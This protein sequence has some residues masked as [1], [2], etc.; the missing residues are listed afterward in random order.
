MKSLYDI[1]KKQN[2][3]DVLVSARELLKYVIQVTH[4][5]PKEYRFS[6]V[7]NIHKNAF[8]VLENIIHANDIYLTKNNLKEF[9]LRNQYQ[10][11]ALAKI[12]LLEC[13]ALISLESNCI[14]MKQYEHM[15]T[16]I[17][18][19]SNLIKAWISSDKKRMNVC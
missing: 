2:K 9:E 17:E 4:K 8:E 10:R 13:F 14:L 15:S 16:L 11:N 18:N 6:L 3:F 7:S 12:Q 5:S 19:C 1:K